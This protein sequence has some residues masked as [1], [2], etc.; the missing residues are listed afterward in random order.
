MLRPNAR[1][2]NKVRGYLAVRK[3]MNNVLACPVCGSA[4]I[5]QS[6]TTLYD[7]L[8][9]VSFS[10]DGEL[11][12]ELIEDSECAGEDCAGAY[13]CT[14]CELE[15]ADDNGDPL[16]EP[17]EIVQFFQAIERQQQSA[18]SQADRE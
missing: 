16:S 14:R 13:Y 8:V 2:E 6:R 1:Q 5:I 3:Q 18:K 11:F 7:E 15:I 17:Q 10:K 4:K 9:I 12:E